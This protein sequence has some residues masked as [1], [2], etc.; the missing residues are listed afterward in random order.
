MIKKYSSEKNVQYLVAYLKAYKIKKVI[1]SPG[2][3]NLSF[4]ASLQCDPFFEIYSCVDER[5]AAYMAVGLSEESGE[6]VVI[7][8]TGATASRNY[9][10]A[11]TEAYYRK[12][13]ILAVTGTKNENS[14][15]QLNSQ[16]IDRRVAQNDVLVHSTYLPSIKDEEDIYYCKL[17]INMALSELTRNGGGPVH[18]NLQTIYSRDFSVESLP[19]VNVV[20]R[21][22]YKDVDRF[23]KLPNGRIGVFAGSHST[24][25]KELTAAIDKFCASHDA[26]VFCDHTSGYYGRYKFNFALPGSQKYASYPE[27]ATLDLCIHIGEISAEYAALGNLKKKEVW[28]VSEDGEMRNQFKHLTHVF[29]MDELDF[30][31]FYTL[32]SHAE[33]TGYIKK[34]KDVY[35]TLYAN[36]PEIPLSNVYIAYQLHDKIPYGS[37]VHF[38]ILN[39]L[40]SWNLFNLPEGV[41]TYGN[42]GG[43]GIDGCMSSMIG[44]SLTNPQKLFF[45]IFGDLSFFYDMN[46]IGNRHIGNN[47][48]ILLVNNGKGQE[49]RNFYH[50]GSL[51]GEDADKYIAAGGHFG[52]KSQSLVRGLAESL[53]YKYYSASTK[54]EFLANSA[55]FVTPEITGQPIIFEV[56]TETQDE[57]DAMLALWSIGK[58]PK[59]LVI[60]KVI[61][62]FGG[63]QKAKKVLGKN[64]VCFFKKILKK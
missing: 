39:S 32:D 54:E 23:P 46:S 51:F 10:S 61:D 44:A 18:I 5:S 12:L 45:G 42:V 38:G 47:I 3:T 50:T 15:G 49:F 53:G 16:M 37:A 27:I 1:A 59:D 7:T 41:T 57:S 24:F 31:S 20:T 58:S 62:Q 64:A 36:I 28:R 17:K 60:G 19:S 33:A 4:V 29:E 43:F 56:F 40:R 30:F 2:T 6:P 22:T 21:L 14:I 25:S 48:R 11:L 55:H 26:V 34:C 35:D 63:K 52:N 8:C 13:P 9:L